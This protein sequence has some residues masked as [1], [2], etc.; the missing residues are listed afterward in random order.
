MTVDL[1]GT[2]NKNL[3][4]LVYNE[5]YLRECVVEKIIRDEQLFIVVEGKGFCKLYNAMEPRFNPIYS[6]QS[7]K[8]HENAFEEIALNEGNVQHDRPERII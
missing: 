6:T 4:L 8:L 5:K 1:N 2:H 3:T 7:S